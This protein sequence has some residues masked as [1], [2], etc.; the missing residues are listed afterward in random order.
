MLEVK[1]IPK[2]TTSQFDDYLF[3]SWKPD[4]SGLYDVFH[5]ERIE[6]YRAFLQLPV[7]PHRRAVYFFLFV[8]K[9][10][11]VRFKGLN[12]YRVTENTFFCLPSDQI[13]AIE[14]ISDD[15]DGFYC[16]FQLEIFN[17]HQVSVDFEKDFPFFKITSE[18]SIFI[19]NPSRITSILEILFEET[20]RKE[21]IRKDLVALYLIILLN[22]V[23]YSANSTAFMQNNAASNLTQRY[24]QLLTEQI[25]SKKTVSEFAELLAVSPNHLHKCVKATTGKSAHELLEDMRI[26]EAKVLLKQTPLRIAEIAFRIGDFEPSDFSRFFKSKTG[27]TPKEYRNTIL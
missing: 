11:T 26:L 23:A 13:T 6:K 8:T 1:N 9:G 2:L 18:P 24:K 27:L 3:G 22:E 5:I 25:Y 15:V 4:V 10:H 14:E 16:H 17:H 21:T 12:K 20:K 19:Q 7:A